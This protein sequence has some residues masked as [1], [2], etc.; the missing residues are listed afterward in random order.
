MQLLV[1]MLT[2]QPATQAEVCHP[3]NVHDPRSKHTLGSR[4]LVL[5]IW[6]IV[7]PGV[8]NIKASS[9]GT[10]QVSGLSVGKRI[11]PTYW[12]QGCA[13]CNTLVTLW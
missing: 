7:C 3:L 4:L 11:V 8:N 13:G 2:G 12:R 9:S 5:S 6:C 10:A 1:D